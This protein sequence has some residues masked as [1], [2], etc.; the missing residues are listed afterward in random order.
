[1]SS[2]HTQVIELQESLSYKDTRS[3]V[4]EQNNNTN[5]S[6]VDVGYLKVEPRVNTAVNTTDGL[7][8]DFALVH[9]QPDS[10]NTVP[11]ITPA[12]RRRANIQYCALC[13]NLFLAGWNDGTTGPLLPGIQENYH[14]GSLIISQRLQ[15]TVSIQAWIYHCLAD[16]HLKLHST[17]ESVNTST[18]S[19][20]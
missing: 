3:V 4:L 18:E 19:S 14:V 20:D 11:A 15:L 13:F 9:Q 10:S 7:P 2:T 17:V 6:K 8:R 5:T 12:M 1:M 16:I